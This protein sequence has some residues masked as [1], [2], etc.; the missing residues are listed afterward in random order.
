MQLTFKSALAHAHMR[1]SCVHMYARVCALAGQV[2][3]G[4]QVGSVL[5]LH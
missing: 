2:R 3:S 1:P 5:F 4:C